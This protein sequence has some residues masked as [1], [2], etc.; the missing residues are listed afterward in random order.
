[1]QCSF[2]NFLPLYSR[3]TLVLSKKVR[4]TFGNFIDYL[5]K[6]CETFMK[7]EWNDFGSIFDDMCKWPLNAAQD[8]RLFWHIF[9]RFM[10]CVIFLKSLAPFSLSK[11]HLTFFFSLFLSLS[12]PFWGLI[13]GCQLSKKKRRL[14]EHEPRKKVTLLWRRKKSFPGE[15]DKKRKG[16]KICLIILDFHCFDQVWFVKGKIIWWN[17]LG[18]VQISLTNPVSVRVILCIDPFCGLSVLIN[19]ISSNWDNRFFF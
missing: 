7:L 14:K 10:P 17:T 1:M 9:S 19:N 6:S 16:Q 13:F 12:R 2:R 15:D 11:R 18:T 4:V 3:I 8:L 5:E